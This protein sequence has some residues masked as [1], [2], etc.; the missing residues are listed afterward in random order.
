MTAEG[1]QD[2]I[3]EGVHDVARLEAPIEIDG[4]LDDWPE[5]PFVMDRP[6]EIVYGDNKPWNG[7]EDA[8]LRFGVARDDENLYVAVEVIDDRHFVS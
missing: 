8:S 1:S 3:I 7:P 5:L 4:S 2:L 6:A